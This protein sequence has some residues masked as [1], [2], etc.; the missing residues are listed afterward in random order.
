LKA[1]EI[2]P[3][4]AEAHNSLAHPLYYYDRDWVGAEREF[5]KSIELNPRYAI[6]HHWYG[7]YLSV[8]GRKEEALEEIRRAQDL[9]PLSLSI[10]VWVGWILAFAGQND[11]ALDQL[12]KTKE[13]DPNFLLTRH[14][15]ALLYADQKRYDE[16]IAEAT[17]MLRISEGRL[18]ALTLGYVYAAAGKK[19]EALEQVDKLVSPSQPRFVS[20][21]AIGMIYGVL[22]DKDTAFKWLEK[23][24]DEHDMLVVRIK[25]DPRFANLRGDPRL[26]DLVKRMG[27]P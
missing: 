27:L 18:G 2:D 19:K 20:P 14:R 5:K 8:V 25:Y 1:L 7:V 23:A 9:D 4:L 6:A 12:L 21:A 24:N 3:T 10:N 11:A 16:A 17:E 15:L 26:D 13:M 22:G